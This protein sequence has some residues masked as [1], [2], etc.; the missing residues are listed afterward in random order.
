MR[1]DH[2]SCGG[3]PQ[4]FTPETVPLKETGAAKVTRAT[5]GLRLS[6]RVTPPLSPAAV[7]GR[8]AKITV[9]WREARI[10]ASWFKGKMVETV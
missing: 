1:L 7:N 10:I 9:F 6:R 5:H 2:E 4:R 8:T 3:N